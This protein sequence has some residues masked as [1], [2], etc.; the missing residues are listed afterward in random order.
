MFAG[1]A[2]LAPSVARR[3]VA[4][5]TRRGPEA[6]ED[7]GRRDVLAARERETLLL[8]GQGLSNSEVAAQLMVSEQT[9]LGLRDLVQ[10]VTCAYETGLIAPGAGWLVRAG[11]GWT[12]LLPEARGLPPPREGHPPRAGSPASAM[13]PAPRRAQ[14]GGRAAPRLG[15]HRGPVPPR[16]RPPRRGAQHL[17]IRRTRSPPSRESI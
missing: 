1:D 17:R 16:R 5:F 6:Q 3:L 2:L 7:G 10:A 14:H 12:E 15:N 9:K 11:A 13:C 8:L 4:D